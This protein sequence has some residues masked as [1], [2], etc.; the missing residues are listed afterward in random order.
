VPTPV[1]SI[2]KKRLERQQTRLF[3][4]EQRLMDMDDLYRAFDMFLGDKLAANLSSRTVHSYRYYAGWLFPFLE[5]HPSGGLSKQALSDWLQTL[6]QRMKPQSVRTAFRS[7]SPFL[8]WCLE[9]GELETD[10]VA[11]VKLPRVQEAKK[12]PL[13]DDEMRRLTEACETTKEQAIVSLLLDTGVR[14]N[15][16]VNLRLENVDLTAKLVHVA[17]TKNKQPRTL[18]FGSKTTRLLR[19][20]LNEHNGCEWLFYS[21][22]RGYIGERMDPGHIWHFVA[23][24]AERARIRR[25]GPHLLRHS[26]ARTFYKNTKD[27]GRLCVFMGH[28]SLTV[29]TRYVNLHFA[30]LQEG[31]A[32]NA[33]M[34]LLRAKARMPVRGLRQR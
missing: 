8:K 3:E 22:K 23:D 4:R 6:L 5:K 18:P 1:S 24:I 14:A 16:L 20:Y 15:E 25:V 12:V 10:L 34:D 30:D 21:H 17:T 11:G 26:F 9:E 7:V 19:S 27:L 31:Y 2:S 13:T 28:G 33:P 32:G 29:T